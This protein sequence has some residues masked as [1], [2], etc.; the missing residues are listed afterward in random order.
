MVM[1][2]ASAVL[3]LSDE[4]AS[5]IPPTPFAKGGVGGSWHFSFF[6]KEG[7]GDFLPY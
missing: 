7:R 6:E 4:V 3:Y 2:Y 5:K 1:G